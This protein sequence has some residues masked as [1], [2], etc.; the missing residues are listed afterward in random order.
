METLD[1]AERLEQL[2]G[3]ESELTGGEEHG[4][5][6]EAEA[7]KPEQTA[8]EAKPDDHDHGDDHGEEA[9]PDGAEPNPD[10]TEAAKEPEKR[11]PEE[12]KAKHTKAEKEAYAW[13]KLNAERARQDAEINRLKA[14]IESLKSNADKFVRNAESL[15]GDPQKF[16]QARREAEMSDFMARQKAAELKDRSQEI[17]SERNRENTRAK[18]DALYASKEDRER[19][20]GTLKRAFDAGFGDIMRTDR[21]RGIV[22]FCDGSP[23][24]PRIIEQLAGCPQDLEAVISK[25]NEM[26]RRILLREIER[27]LQTK[28]SGAS[29]TEPPKA[30]KSA[31][32]QDT[33]SNGG[34]LPNIGSV[35][36]GRTNVGGDS[37]FADDSATLDYLR[38]A[39][40]GIRIR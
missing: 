7:P 14:Q 37:T 15:K 18:I 2:I 10:G 13:D 16:E 30:A 6:H 8:T 34:A 26:D 24:G 36:S 19:Y 23:I 29:K 40:N 38:S 4:H 35:G 32:A 17:A 5:D 3:A 25:A 22:E 21:G 9:T 33:Q 1:G 27:G 28:F 39:G 11:E 20:D 12:P 31:A